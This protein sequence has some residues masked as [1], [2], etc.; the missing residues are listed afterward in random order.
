MI[1]Q[2][3]K[4]FRELYKDN[5]I[6]QIVTL[7]SHPETPHGRQKRAANDEVSPTKGVSILYYIIAV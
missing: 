2:V 4:T 1:F 3:T 7:A 6:V 5:V